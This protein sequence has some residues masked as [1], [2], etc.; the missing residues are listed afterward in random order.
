M[1]KNRVIWSEGLFLRPHHFQQQERF[2][3]GLIDQRQRATSRFAWGFT[4]IEIDQ[5]A[6][7]QGLLQINRA[8]GVLPDGTAFNLPDLDPPPV[9]LDFPASAKDQLCFVAL[10]LGRQGV[11][12]TNLDAKPTPASL[13]RFHASITEAI[14]NNEGFGENAELQV[15][16]MSL[17][18]IRE[19]ERTG[20]FSG[21]AIAR[22]LE[23]RVDGQVIIDPSF[24]PP[25]LSVNEN[26]ILRSYCNE[27]L[28]LLRQRGDAI[29][30]RMGEPGKGGVAEIA[31]FLLLQLINRCRT[32]FE[33]LTALPNYHPEEFYCVLIQMV[34]ELAT[35]AGERR[36][37]PHIAPYDHDNLALCFKS[38]M[39]SLR[40]AL[41][42]QLEQTAIKIDLMD[43]NYGLRLG[44]IADKTLLKT[45]SFVLAVHAQVPGEI[46]RSGFPSKVKI[47]PAERIRHLVNFQL[48]GIPTQALPVAPRQIPFHAGYSYFQLDTQ[49]EMWKELSN[50]GGICI[51]VPV[52]EFPGIQMEFW[53][54]KT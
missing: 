45:C 24:I 2:F 31:E 1:W 5:A 35:F 38:V 26:P 14:D 30:A 22:I 44:I 28:G 20:A 33:H 46:V 8:S 52:D 36:V 47:G 7:S 6:L 41:T 50:S 15:G 25:C 12:S 29:A 4:S 34:G 49:H 16:R 23:R 51:H 54:I 53:A 32:L 10:P 21:L 11:A 18:I 42:N 48:Q 19:P 9:P 27:V 37:P 39:T 3:E 40:L 13:T 43:K 17:R